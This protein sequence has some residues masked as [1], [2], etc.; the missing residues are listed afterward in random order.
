M[1]SDWKPRCGKKF[2]NFAE[3]QDFVNN[4]GQLEQQLFVKRRSPKISDSR[5]EKWN[6][7]LEYSEVTFTCK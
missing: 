3:A 4:Y 6:R 1:E 5:K 7:H 2:Q